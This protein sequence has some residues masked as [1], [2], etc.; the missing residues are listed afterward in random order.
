MMMPL[1]SKNY[2]SLIISIFT[3]MPSSFLSGIPILPAV[4]K[5]PR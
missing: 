3:K 1:S 5:S 4:V 2:S